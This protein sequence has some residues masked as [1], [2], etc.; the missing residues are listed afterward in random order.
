MKLSQINFNLSEPSKIEIKD[1]VTKKSFQTPAYIYIM[2][3]ESKEGKQCQLSI[4]KEIMLMRETKQKD[5]EPTPE[6]IRDASL[7][8]LHLLVKGWE[9]VEDDEGKPLEYS[10]ENAIRL[11]KDY[12]LI[13]NIVNIESSKLGNFIK[14]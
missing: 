6:E 1:P 5:E 12:E 11:L 7:K 9:G 10:E 3:I 2:S 13:Y 4:F 14:G 8:H